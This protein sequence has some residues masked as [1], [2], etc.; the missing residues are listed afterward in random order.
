MPTWKARD[1]IHVQVLFPPDQKD[2]KPCPGLPPPPAP[3]CVPAPYFSV[4]LMPYVSFRRKKCIHQL[5]TMKM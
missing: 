3:V 2:L 4:Y 5:H 1:F